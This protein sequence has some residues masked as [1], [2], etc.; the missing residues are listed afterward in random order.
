MATGSLEFVGIAEG[1]RNH[2]LSVKRKIEQLRGH[3]YELSKRNS[4]LQIDIA[5]LEAEIASARSQID[6]NGEPNHQLIASLEAQRSIALSELAQVESDIVCTNNELEQSRKELDNVLEEKEQTLFEIQE[7][8]RK[9]S[10][11]I[12]IAGGMLRDYSG[13]GISLQDSMQMSLSSLSH[14]A[15]ILDSSIDSMSTSGIGGV[16][17]DLGSTMAKKTPS[18][19]V[20][21]S[22]FSAF[23]SGL[24]VN[25]QGNLRKAIL[26]K[27][28]VASSV[29][30]AVNES[31][32]ANQADLSFETTGKAIAE[33]GDI[34]SCGNDVGNTLNDS[35]NI[36]SQSGNVDSMSVG[37]IGEVASALESTIAKKKSSLI[38]SVSAFSAFASELKEKA[39]DNITKAVI[40]T[41]T[42]VG[43]SGAAIEAV[44]EPNQ[45]NQADFYAKTGVVDMVDVGESSVEQELG[46]MITD[47][48]ID[49]G[50]MIETI[51]EDEDNRI[52]YIADSL[53]RSEED[54]EIAEEGAKVSEYGDTPPSH[55]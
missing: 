11:N 21:T 53:E 36:S 46:N 9:K 24:K 50:Q 37:G 28:F 48:I 47:V 20:S 4:S 19:T 15:T 12:T 3:L 6:Q 23:T 26:P 52:G 25:T 43:L 35:E 51:G 16:S 49:A 44:N 34:N 38:V 30:K 45:V 17:S 33:E 22:A 40:V 18:S 2:E 5:H 39:K 14:A 27:T 55:D 42:L 54:E 7:R 31:G 8:A 41:E 1:I 10:R 13:V 29:S 32:Q